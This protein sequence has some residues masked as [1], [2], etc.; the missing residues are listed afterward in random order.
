MSE[1]RVNM[2]SATGASIFAVGLAVAGFGLGGYID[3]MSRPPAAE[4]EA[5]DPVYYQEQTNSRNELAITAGG[6]ALTLVGFGVMAADQS[7]IRREL[8]Y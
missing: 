5:I 2:V 1:I 4:I 8:G 6:L 7:R 3:K